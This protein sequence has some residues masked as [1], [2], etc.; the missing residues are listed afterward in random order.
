MAIDRTDHDYGDD[1]PTTSPRFG[2]ELTSEMGRALAPALELYD[3]YEDEPIEVLELAVKSKIGLAHTLSYNIETD[4]PL[5]ENTVREFARANK[6]W[7]PG[8]FN[9]E[10]WQFKHCEAEMKRLHNPRDGVWD[11]NAILD[12]SDLY[13]CKPWAVPFVL[14]L[15]DRK[16]PFH[17][18]LGA[19]SEMD[20]ESRVSVYELKPDEA[21]HLSRVTKELRSHIISSDEHEEMQ[22]VIELAADREMLAEEILEFFANY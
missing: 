16:I 20:A 15:W 14:K 11:E 7:T 9:P 12:D 19:I 10:A 21:E 3:T 8:F 13:E 18:F 1:I 17:S 6:V 2:I 4:L 5:P 22:V